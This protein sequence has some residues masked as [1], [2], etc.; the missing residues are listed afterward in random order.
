[1]NHCSQIFGA[2]EYQV[3]LDCLRKGKPLNLWIPYGCRWEGVGTWAAKLSGIGE[4]MEVACLGPQTVD[5]A[6]FS[7]HS[8]VT[9]CHCLHSIT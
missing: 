5:G 1:M 3:R 9:Y 2:T 8:C 7:L 6:S 4:H